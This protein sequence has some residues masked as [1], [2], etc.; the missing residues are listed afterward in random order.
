VTAAGL[1]PL[2]W[3]AAAAAAAAAQEGRQQPQPR[4]SCDGRSWALGGANPPIA[5][6]ADGWGATAGLRPAVQPSA[7]WGRLAF[8]FLTSHRAVPRSTMRRS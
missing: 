5:H 2:P 7:R 3:S 8:C 1:L 4:R 6:A